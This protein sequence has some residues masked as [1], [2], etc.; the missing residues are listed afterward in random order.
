MTQPRFRYHPDPV[1]TGS[2]VPTVE[3]C[4]LCGVERG[5]RY[6]GP[7]YG[8]QAAVLCLHCIASGEAARALTGA[9]DFSCMFTEA[10]LL[11]QRAGLVKHGGRRPW[12]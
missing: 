12:T 2:A 7:I 8:R 3:A 10:A 11:A 1:A 6:A 5:W 4:V 9:A